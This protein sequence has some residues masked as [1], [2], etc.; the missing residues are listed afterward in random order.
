MNRNVTTGSP[1]T[2]IEGDFFAGILKL[3]RNEREIQRSIYGCLRMMNSITAV[4]GLRDMQG[5][6]LVAGALHRAKRA[7][8]S[9]D[10]N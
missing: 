10:R 7:R 1:F 9:P 5:S 4:D 6:H 3:I 8:S 2:I